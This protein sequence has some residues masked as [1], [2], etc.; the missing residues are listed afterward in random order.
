MVAD[1]SDATRLVLS[2]ALQIGHHELVAE[3]RDGVETIEKFRT[4]NPDVLLLD[5]AMPRKDGLFVLKEI[6][7]TKPDAKIIMLTAN[8]DF[9][10]INQSSIDGAQAYIIKPFD[11][12]DVLKAISMVLS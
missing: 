6:I 9:S 1:D 5:I 2:D 11:F 4:T 12:E 3:A 8:E 7:S 10:K